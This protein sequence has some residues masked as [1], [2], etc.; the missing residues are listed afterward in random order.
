MSSFAADDTLTKPVYDEASVGDIR[1]IFLG[2]DTLA[3]QSITWSGLNELVQTNPSGDAVAHMEDYPMVFSDVDTLG[4]AN[5]GDGIRFDRIYEWLA[6][7]STWVYKYV[8]NMAVGLSV[9][10]FTS[11]NHSIDSV[12][13]TL[14]ERRDDGSLVKQIDSQQL[15]TGM[16]ALTA[17]NDAVAIIHL[18]SSKPFKIGQGNKLRLQIAFIST[19]T[20]IA[21]TFEGVMPAFYFQEGSLAKWLTPSALI[22][23]VHPALD[24]AISFTRSQNLKPDIPPSNSFFNESGNSLACG[25]LNPNRLA[26]VTKPPLANTTPS[27]NFANTNVIVK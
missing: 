19:D 9:T 4:I 10:A 21:T 13:F 22:L 25:I 1:T 18:E 24:S 23:Y 26:S 14:S 6:D 17:V 11:G 16:T 3:L 7:M 5:E 15:T 20:D 27:I 12:I 8:I 2:T